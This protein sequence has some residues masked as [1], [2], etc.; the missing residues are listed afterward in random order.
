[1]WRWRRAIPACHEPISK[2]V[3]NPIIKIRLVLPLCCCS[4]CCHMAW[5]TIHKPSETGTISHHTPNSVHP[6]HDQ[7]RNCRLRPRRP[8]AHN[9]GLVLFE[10]IFCFR[11]SGFCEG[12]PLKK[13]RN[14]NAS[15]K[16]Q[17][18]IT[19]GGDPRLPLETTTHSSGMTYGRRK[20]VSN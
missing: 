11:Y 8:H 5:Y 3:I 9:T 19:D 17:K 18:Q 2:N 20:A 6:G 1:M 4:V 14:R 13:R 7:H 12:R 10:I 16:I 15:L